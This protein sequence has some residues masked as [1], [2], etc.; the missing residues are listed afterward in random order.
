MFFLS[1]VAVAVQD[2]CAAQAVV[3]ACC[4]A[5][6]QVVRPAG[7][8]A[9]VQALH[10]ASAAPAA[11]VPALPWAWALAA[12]AAELPA[13]LRLL[14]SF[15]SAGTTALLLVQKQPVPLRQQQPQQQVLAWAWER[16]R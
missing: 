12:R 14:S 5:R 8:V 7:C 9:A 16:T 13:V 10:L 1:A 11:A 2:D 6:V 4:A 3:Q 15:S